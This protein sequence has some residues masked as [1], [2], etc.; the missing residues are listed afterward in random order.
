MDIVVFLGGFFIM[1][2]IIG[3]IV[4]EFNYYWRSYGEKNFY[5]GIVKYKYILFYFIYGYVDSVL[6]IW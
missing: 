2:C 5:I 6:Y 1:K 3:N 4:Y